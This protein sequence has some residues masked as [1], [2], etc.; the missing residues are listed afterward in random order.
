MVGLDVAAG[1]LW[2]LPSYEALGDYKHNHRKLQGCGMVAK[3]APAASVEHQQQ[4][5]AGPVVSAA[6]RGDHV[7]KSKLDRAAQGAPLL[8]CAP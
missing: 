4:A 7:L 3:S 5:K 2:A 1:E 8:A 6:V